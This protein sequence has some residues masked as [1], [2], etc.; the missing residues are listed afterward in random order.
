MYIPALT[1]HLLQLLKTRDFFALELLVQGHSGPIFPTASGQL[2]TTVLLK[3]KFP[4]PQ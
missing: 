4:D 2:V 3:L 1:N